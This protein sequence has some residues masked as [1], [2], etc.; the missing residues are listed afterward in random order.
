ML[1]EEP[2]ALKSA[3]AAREA[4]REAQPRAHACAAIPGDVVEAEAV[5]RDALSAAGVSLGPLHGLPIVVKDIIDVAGLPTKAGSATRPGPAPAKG[6]ATVVAKLRAAGAITVA[7]THTVEFAFGG[8]GTNASQGTPRNPWKPDEPHTP[9]GSSSGTGVAVG[10]RYVAAGLG[11]DTGGSVRIP[12]AFCGCVGLKTSI[13][14]VSRAGVVPLSDTFDTIGPLTDTVRRAAE[15]LDAMQGEDRAD[16]ATLGISRSDP[17][18]GLERGIDGLRLAVLPDEALSECMPEVRA[19]FAAALGQL[20][21]AGAV[22]VPVALPKSFAEYQRHATAIISSDAYAF[23]AALADSNEAPLND[24]TRMRMIMG[25]DMSARDRVDAQ[26]ARQADIADFLTALDRAD[27][28]V[29]PTAPVTA[30]PLSG[31]DEN[32]YVMSL[33]TRIGNY[34]DLAGLSVP[35]GLTPGGLPTSLQIL[36]RRFDDPLALRIGHAFEAVRGPFPAPPGG[37]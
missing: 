16:P 21:D 14:L 31:V 1:D 19:S 34:L 24:T 3:V 29:L 22:I 32:N 20:R 30:I 4:L 36:V 6:D 11:T 13:G 25:R 33:Y 26:R 27:A 8:W 10:G 35:I 37:E 18:S 12:A 9:G 15:M 28:L 7:K 17:L 23:H 2:T 5:H